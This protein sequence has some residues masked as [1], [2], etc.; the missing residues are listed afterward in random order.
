MNEYEIK[1]EEKYK[2]CPN[3]AKKGLHKSKIC[4]LPDKQFRCKYCDMEYEMKINKG[5]VCW[6]GDIPTF[7]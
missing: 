6:I 4:I 1:H 3:C 2:H 7:G 5:E